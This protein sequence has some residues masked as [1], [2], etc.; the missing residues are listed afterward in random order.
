M[1]L[2]FDCLLQSKILLIVFNVDCFIKTTWGFF[3]VSV[4]PFKR[5]LL[6]PNQNNLLFL[7][8]CKK[9]N[10]RIILW[11]LKQIKDL[12]RTSWSCGQ[13]CQCI[14]PGRLRFEYR[15]R[16]IFLKCIC[17]FTLLITSL[18]PWF[19]TTF[20]SP[21]PWINTWCFFSHG[22]HMISDEAVKWSV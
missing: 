20:R 14:T 22:Y 8:V 10:S 2:Y 11:L 9:N 3:A 7:E 15:H 4:K 16:Q 21:G 6:K 19:F 1:G 12:C 13:I 5:P 17:V 18:F